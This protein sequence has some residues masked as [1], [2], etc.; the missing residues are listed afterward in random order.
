MGKRVT[1]VLDDYLVKKLRIIQS[2]EIA[3]SKV[4]ISFSSVVNEKLRKTLR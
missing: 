4:S 1:V 3:K 2:K